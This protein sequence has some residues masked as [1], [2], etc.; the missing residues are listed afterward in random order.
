MIT[1]STDFLTESCNNKFF[2]FTEETAKL[3]RDANLSK[4]ARTLWDYIVTTNPFGDEEITAPQI[5]TELNGQVHT[6]YRAK[7]E[8][9]KAGLVK[10]KKHQC[11]LISTLKTRVTRAVERVTKTVKGFDKNEKGI[12][13]NCK[14]IEEN[15]QNESPK[16]L[17]IK[18]SGL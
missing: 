16:A 5:L 6:Y 14:S 17:S 8:L 1:K 3:L 15:C 18:D 13:K 12:Y 9:E 11:T 10:V 4:N 2:K 7:K